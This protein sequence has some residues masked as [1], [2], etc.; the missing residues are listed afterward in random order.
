MASKHRK[1]LLLVENGTARNV[2]LTLKATKLAYLPPN[3]TSKLKPLDQDIIVNFKI[4]YRQFVIERFLLN[5]EKNSD[6]KI[7]V[8][9]SDNSY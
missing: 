1:V 7:D 2:S 4:C 3:T 8:M 5:F 9:A 6:L